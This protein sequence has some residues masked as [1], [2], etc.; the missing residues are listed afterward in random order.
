MIARDSHRLRCSVINGCPHYPLS[1][2]PHYPAVC[3]R[4]VQLTIFQKEIV[5]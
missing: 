2:L 5:P 3:F 4:W 1:P